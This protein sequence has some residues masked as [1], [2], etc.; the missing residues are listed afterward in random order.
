[1]PLVESKYASVPVKTA[2]MPPGVPY[3]VANEAAE[4]FSYYGMR[5]ILVVFMTHYMMTSSGQPDHMTDPQ[6]RAW[7]HFF[8]GTVYF[9]PL[10]G[11]ILADAFLGKY[12]TIV[13]L[14]VVYCLGHLALALDSTRMGMALGLGLIAIGSG[15]IKPCVSAHVGDQFGP[16]NQRLLP[17]VFSWFYFS[18]N[19]GS[20]IATLLIPFLLKRYGPHVAFGTPGLLMLIAT[21]FFWLGRR[22]FVHIPPGGKAFVRET[23][24][25]QGLRSLGQLL[26]IYLFLAVFWS[27]YDQTGGAWVLQAEKMNRYLFGHEMLAAQIQAA[28]PLLILIYIPLFT[29]VIYPVVNR[30]F[31]LTPLRKISIGLFLIAGS[32][33]IP[34]WV[35]TRINAGFTPSIGWQLFAYA[36]LIASEI[37]VSITA[38]EFSYTQA[39]RKMKSLVMGLFLLSISLGDMFTAAVNVIIQNKDGTTKLS[40]VNYYLFFAGLMFATA[41]LFIVVAKLY[42]GQTF[43]QG[44]EETPAATV[45]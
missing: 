6:A 27:L 3:I 22:K 30:F 21:W 28:N 32:F 44:D 2:A 8:M 38:L 39:P 11:A 36:F 13:S 23:F 9:F 15:G 14:S 4:R 43:I 37:L 34:A 29:Y 19:F 31:P 7:Y 18:I 16:A 40:G 35:E 26:V 5:S 25:R 42:R 17:K 1:M 41:L 33:L 10:L 45:T 20:A 24:S 12:L